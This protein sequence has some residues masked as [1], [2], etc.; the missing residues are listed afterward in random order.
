MEDFGVSQ[1]ATVHFSFADEPAGRSTKIVRDI[2]EQEITNSIIKLTRGG[3][4]KV[5][6]LT[7]HGEADLT[8]E[9]E[10]GFLYLKEAI[11]GENIAVSTLNFSETH[12]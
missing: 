11:E 6:V 2:T 12:T 1:S 8:K 5:Y 10:A 7:G 4:K 9:V 3:E